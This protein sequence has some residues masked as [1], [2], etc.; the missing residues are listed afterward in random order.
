MGDFG[1]EFFYFLSLATHPL[2]IAL[3][4]SIALLECLLEIVAINEGWDFVL[5]NAGGHQW[6]DLVDDLA[7]DDILQVS[8]RLW[9]D[10]SPSKRV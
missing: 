10:R 1:F 2:V 4:R 3:H 8:F 9:H 5:R 6:V 7:F